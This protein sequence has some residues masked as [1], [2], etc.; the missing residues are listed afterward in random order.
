MRGKKRGGF[1][2]YIEYGFWIR[3]WLVNRGDEGVKGRG[4]G[5]G[6]K[7]GMIRGGSARRGGRRTGEGGGA[8]GLGGEYKGGRRGDGTRGRIRV[9]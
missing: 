1:G 7:W 3:L 8:M 5:E 9:R 4:V 6:D 2:I